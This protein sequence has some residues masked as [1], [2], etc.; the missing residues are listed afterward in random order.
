MLTRLQ[1]D[2]LKAT[3]EAGAILRRLYQQSLQ[4]LTKEDGSPVTEADQAVDLFFQTHLKRLTPDIPIVSEE[5]LPFPNRKDLDAPF[6]LLDPLDGTRS[7]VDQTGEFV[8]SLALI[9]QQK[10]IWGILHTP[11]LKKTYMAFDGNAFLFDGERLVPLKSPTVPSDWTAL[12]GASSKIVPDLFAD[13]PIQH[14]QRVQ[15]ALKCCWL[16]E[17]KGQFSWRF[18]PCYEWDIAAGHALLEAI[19]GGICYLDGRS[20]YYG[21]TPHYHLTKGLVLYGAQEVRHLDGN[22]FNPKAS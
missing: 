12:I 13:L 15:S 3:Q 22:R 14:I 6:W 20:I 10:P 11:L 7:F 21:T 8:I 4:P 18:S 19:G 16:A 2:L 1:T 17:G 9:Q 5:N